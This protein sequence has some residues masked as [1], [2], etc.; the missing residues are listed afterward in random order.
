MLFKKISAVIDS[1]RFAHGGDRD[2]LINGLVK[3]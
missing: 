3:L 2:G 1:A